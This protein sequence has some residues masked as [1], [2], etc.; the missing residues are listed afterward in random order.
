[1]TNSLD[2]VSNSK[3]CRL[4]YNI[5]KQRCGLDHILITF[6]IL[7]MLSKLH[8][9]N[10]VIRSDHHYEICYSNIFTHSLNGT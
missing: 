9:N 2:V 8:Y 5:Y 10:N 4:A 7:F 6:S 3:H 1:M